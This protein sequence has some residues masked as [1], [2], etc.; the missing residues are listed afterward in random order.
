MTSV[1]EKLMKRLRA[2]RERNERT[3]NEVAASVGISRS[4][5]AQ[6]ESGQ[7]AVSAE[8]LVRFASFFQMSCEELLN[9]R[10][11]PRVTLQRERPAARKTGDTASTIRI[12]VPQE[13]ERKFREVLLYIL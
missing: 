11:E 4:A 6:I 1:A 2:L 3:Q 13:D 7:R 8:E 9:P 10:R 12:S 5:L